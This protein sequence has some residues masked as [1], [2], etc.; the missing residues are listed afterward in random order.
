MKYFLIARV[1]REDQI[2]ALPAQKKRLLEYVNRKGETDYEYYEF[3]ETAHTIDAR[4]E[5]GKIIERIKKEAQKHK[6]IVVFDKIDRFTRDSSQD[7]VKM[8]KRLISTDSI[9][10]HF[11]HDNLYVTKHS[12]ATDLF[13]MGI[14]MEL[15]AYYSNT[16]SDN[17]RRRFDEMV[18][19]GQY[20]HQAPYGYKNIDRGTRQHPDKDIVI[21]EQKAQYVRKIYSLR[22]Q[23]LSYDEICSALYDAGMRGNTGKKVSKTAIVNILANKFYIGI[24]KHDGKEYPHRYKHIITDDVFY[25]CQ[26]VNENRKRVS[27]KSNTRTTFTFGNRIATCKRCG[28]TISCYVKKGNVYL[29]CAGNKICRNP[30]CSEKLIDEAVLS[31]LKR[32]RIDKAITDDIAGILKNKYEDEATFKKDSK[33]AIRKE[34]DKLTGKLTLLYQDRLD[35]RITSSTYDEFA[36]QIQSR[37]DDLERQLMKLD[38]DDESVEINT[39]Y[40]LDLVS[41]MEEL[42]KSSKPELKNKLLRFLFSNLQIDNKTV[43]CSLNDPFK[44]IEDEQK[45]T[46]DISRVFNLAGAE[47]FEPSNGGTRTHCLTTWRRSKIEIFYHESPKK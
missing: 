42:Y 19:K 3:N 11:P 28:R 36:T 46:P 10:I 18:G 16:I 33:E 44:T 1:S 4:K 6:I 45:N 8:F 41:R 30:N 20:P 43:Y 2:D 38:G 35:G 27:C 25:A 24:M 5:F 31:I 7:E 22:L 14:G 17:V 21:D 13:R 12:P 39:S 47:G 37:R 23:H 34:Y 29:R 40:L 9:E 32:V 26:E 15:A